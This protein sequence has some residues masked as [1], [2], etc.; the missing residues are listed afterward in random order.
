MSELPGRE[1]VRQGPRAGRAPTSPAIAAAFV[2][3]V[4]ALIVAVTDPGDLYLVVIAGSGFSVIAIA[5]LTEAGSAELRTRRAFTAL[6]GAHGLAAAILLS[7]LAP[8]VPPALPLA[9]LAA[10]AALGGACVAIRF[11]SM[12]DR[13]PMPLAIAPRVAAIA[14][15]IQT[16]LQ[17]WA[18]SA[19]ARVAPF[20][21]GGFLAQAAVGTVLLASM[22]IIALRL[23]RR[24]L[25]AGLLAWM[26]GWMA[27]MAD[28]GAL[29]LWSLGGSFPTG[30]HQLP[31]LDAELV[32]IVATLG[33]LAIGAALVRAIPESRFRHSA[34]M[35]LA[36]YAAFGLITAVGEHRIDLAADFPSIVALRRDRDLAD[37]ITGV[38]LAG[39]LWLYWR[40]VAASSLPAATWKRTDARE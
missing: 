34:M 10:A 2:G 18:A 29:T 4:I 5:A 22:S 37:A 40:R 15:V 31:V 20:R 17:F 1:D 3:H 24:W 7:G 12:P 30:R 21:A 13:L 9:A 32:Q 19:S 39:M 14:L 33:G 8:S 38:A 25:I 6:I 28:L 35:L 16:I 23:R 26:V 36:G 27:S 11:A